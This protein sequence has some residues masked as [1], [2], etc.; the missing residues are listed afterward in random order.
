MN[1]DSDSLYI[2]AQNIELAYLHIAKVRL[3]LLD[4]KLYSSW[5]QLVVAS[6]LLD[7]ALERLA[8]N[9]RQ[10]RESL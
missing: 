7:S 6:A 2:L 8:E 1:N 4:Q 9:L 3:E 5:S 10:G